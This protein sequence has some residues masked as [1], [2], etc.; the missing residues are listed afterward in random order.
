MT[1]QPVI[2]VIATLRDAFRT[3]AGMVGG[4]MLAVLISM[5]IVVPLY[6]PYD[7]VRTWGD[8]TAWVN[9][10]KSA[11]PEWVDLFESGTLPRNTILNR[12]D[13]RK[14]QF[15]SEL[16]G[17][18]IVV[19]RRVFS[20]SYDDFPSELTLWIW[21]S[22]GNISPLVS[23]EF[24]RP[25]GE[26]LDLITF[27]PDV[28]DPV[29][30]LLPISSTVDPAM[31]ETLG[32]I[33]NWAITK[34]NATDVAF[35]KPEVTLFAMGGEDMLDPTR[36]RVLKGDYAIR[37]V[38]VS[39]SPTDDV[40]AKLI[41]YG[42][43]FG[44]AGTDS[45]RRDLLTGLMWGAPVALAFGTVAAL[46]IILVQTFFGVVSA[47]YGGR[48]DE[49]VQRASDFFLIIPLLPILILIGLFYRPS[50]FL[51]LMLI[52]GFSLV[53]GT[54]KVVRSIVFQVKEEQYVESALSYG[55]GNMR[56]LLRHLFPRV[57]PLTFAII[58]LNVPAYIFLEASLSFLNVGDPVLPTWGSIMG[59]AYARN[60][61]FNGW[62]WWVALPA[63]GIIFTTV[64]F[65]LL[66]YSFDKVLN[67]RLREQ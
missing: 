66:G 30:T 57:L 26:V 50:I 23:I 65:A 64:A 44:L 38:A 34:F 63:T 55:T 14:D 27:L 53:G 1:E 6:A 60:A 37:V 28:R 16:F 41:A 49:I 12:E 29:A 21:A 11:A 5:V 3:P 24:E 13:F 54:T 32:R 31:A 9:N 56:I 20:Y 7:V 46:V 35:P 8:S 48:A 17:T 10:P 45:R 51:I 43:V 58:A 42:K 25:D 39:F 19:L 2:G 33:R 59:D 40:D 36:A 15:V 22:F 67:P 47:W 4:A 61:L 52:I 18:N 62:W